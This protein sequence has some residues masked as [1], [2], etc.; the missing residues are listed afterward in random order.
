M[1]IFN[2]F[3]LVTSSNP[4]WTLCSCHKYGTAICLVSSNGFAMSRIVVKT[5]IDSLII[6]GHSVF[7][8][9]MLMH[10]SS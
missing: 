1:P 4:I 3:D 10:V 8:I 6:I 9:L 7:H 5:L 2:S